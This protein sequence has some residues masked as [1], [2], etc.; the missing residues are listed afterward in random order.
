MLRLKRYK[1]AFNVPNGTILNAIGRTNDPA[2]IYDVNASD[3]KGHRIVKRM[4]F[5]NIDDHDP[6]YV[7]LGFLARHYDK[8]TNEISFSISQS[9]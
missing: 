5:K 7:K 6:E 2:S 3:A 9:N 1:D 8:N 4:K